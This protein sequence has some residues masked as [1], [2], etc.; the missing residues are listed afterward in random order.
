MAAKELD[1]K[2]IG[3]E[4]ELNYFEIACKRCGFEIENKINANE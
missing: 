2:F 4:K 1:R 3:I